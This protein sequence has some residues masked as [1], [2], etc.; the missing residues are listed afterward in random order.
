MK[1][2]IHLNGRLNIELTPETP[3]ERAVVEEMLAHAEKGK[4]VR[5]ESRTIA[6]DPSVKP[7]VCAVVS[8]EK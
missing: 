6:V 5:M 1:V 3:L 8:V 4:A 7:G 2:E